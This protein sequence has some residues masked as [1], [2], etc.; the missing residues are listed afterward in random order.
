MGLTD[1]DMQDITG[2]WQKTVLAVQTSLM[3]KKKFAWQMLNC[4]QRPSETNPAACGAASAGAPDQSLTNPKAQ[5][6][7]W[8]RK[9]C[10]R[11]SPFLQMALMM[12]FSAPPHTSWPVVLP[13]PEQDIASFLLVRGEFAW[14]GYGYLGCS[15]DRRAFPGNDW[16]SSGYGWPELLDRDY[17]VPTTFCTETSPGVSEVFTREWSKASIAL[18]CRSFEATITMKDEDI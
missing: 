4:G 15:S 14:L 5:C 11:G 8:M 18:D 13:Y 2:E 9:Y 12:G 7:S 3:A 10:N 17:G 1:K 6:T 16:P